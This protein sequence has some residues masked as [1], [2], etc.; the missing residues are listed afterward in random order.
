MSA[1][2][3]YSEEIAERILDGLMEGRT[4]TGICSD[5]GMPSTSTVRR[6]GCRRLRKG[7]R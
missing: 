3:A 2:T 6:C 1:P 7:R 5:P 4:L